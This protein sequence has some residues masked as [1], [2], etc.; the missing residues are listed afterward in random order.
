M[1]NSLFDMP[2]D[3]GLLPVIGLP[4]CD[5]GAAAAA[6]ATAAL[7]TARAGP[8]GWRRCREPRTGPGVSARAPA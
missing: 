8:P 4:R 5:D 7:P 3:V 2:D 6:A 1:H